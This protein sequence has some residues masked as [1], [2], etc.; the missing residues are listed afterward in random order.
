MGEAFFVVVVVF[1]RD[2]VAPCGV[3]L[4]VVVVVVVFDGVR[5]AVLIS[6]T[7][8]L[9][10]RLDIHPEPTSVDC[11]FATEAD[12]AGDCLETLW[13]LLLFD[14]GGGDEWCLLFL[15]AESWNS[16]VESSVV[17]CRF[18]C[19]GTT[20]GSTVARTA[21]VVRVAAAIGGGMMGWL[22]S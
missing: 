2:R 18:A 1:S 12:E 20:V 16:S 4:F 6:A 17:R 3:L 8:S 10:W 13:L 9:A 15:E 19:G 5:V 11:F 7:N 14:C 21:I 22:S